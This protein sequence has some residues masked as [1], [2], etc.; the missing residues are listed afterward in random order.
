[1][2]SIMNGVTFRPLKEMV[3]EVLNEAIA[4]SMGNMAVMAAPMTMREVLAASNPQDKKMHLIHT[5]SAL[6]AGLSHKSLV[7][8]VDAHGE[9]TYAPTEDFKAFWLERKGSPD[10]Q[11]WSE[12]CAL[13]PKK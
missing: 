5:A 2:H 4:I 13:H 1:M 9:N 6:T 12:W 8:A 3:G 10:K 7:S 11:I